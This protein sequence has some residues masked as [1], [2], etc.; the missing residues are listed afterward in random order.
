MSWLLMLFELDC[1]WLWFELVDFFME[2]C[3]FGWIIEIGYQWKI[4]QEFVY[5]W[6]VNFWG[7]DEFMVI[8]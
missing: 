1:D 2:F 8:V 6:C 3:Q 7:F 5:V 4:F